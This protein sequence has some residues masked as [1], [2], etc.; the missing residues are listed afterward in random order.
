[1]FPHVVEGWAS[2]PP[3]PPGKL[4]SPARL[5]E[6]SGWLLG[7][8]GE[9]AE[10]PGSPS[11]WPWTANVACPWLCLPTAAAAR[12]RQTSR[13]SGWLCSL[14]SG[15]LSRSMAWEHRPAPPI[16]AP[17]SPSPPVLAPC[18]SKA[19]SLTLGVPILGPWG[20]RG[21]G[22]T[23]PSPEPATNTVWPDPVIP[24]HSRCAED[25]G[26]AGLWF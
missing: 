6:R 16:N 5:Q 1:M 19:A 9:L 8:H 4:P 23:L 17:W 20:E 12:L 11:R 10:K 2:H 15:R 7:P 3:G 24:R 22:V 14:N 21:S 18:S 25:E 13:K 26:W